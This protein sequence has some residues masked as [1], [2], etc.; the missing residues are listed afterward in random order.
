M[1]CLRFRTQEK[2]VRS[3][4]QPPT[5]YQTNRHY[6][7]QPTFFFISKVFFDPTSNQ[8]KFFQQVR[9]KGFATPKKRTNWLLFSAR[10]RLVCSKFFLFRVKLTFHLSDRQ[11]TMRSFSHC[12]QQRQTL[13]TISLE[14]VTIYKMPSLCSSVNSTWSS[15]RYP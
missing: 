7:N 5:R 2:I 4:N 13:S 11:S 15:T 3:T 6:L 9:L 10:L 14:Y 8:L 1:G 12:A